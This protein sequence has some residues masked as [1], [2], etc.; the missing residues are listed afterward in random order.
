MKDKGVRPTVAVYGSHDGPTFFVNES[1]GNV[2][3]VQD[4]DE[5]DTTTR[6]MRNR[7]VIKSVTV[8]RT[9]EQARLFVLQWLRDNYYIRDF[10]EVEDTGVARGG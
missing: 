5:G 9:H 8:V 6:V 2:A 7:G 3:L 4:M 10:R 1:N